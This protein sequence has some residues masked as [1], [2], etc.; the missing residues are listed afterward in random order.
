M[1]GHSASTE[2]KEVDKVRKEEEVKNKLLAQGRAVLANEKPPYQW[3][4]EEWTCSRRKV[5]CMFYKNKDDKAVPS[6]KND[7]F[8]KYKQTCHRRSLDA[9][10]TGTASSN[11]TC[12]IDSE[13]EGEGDDSD[14]DNEPLPFVATRKTNKARRTTTVTHQDSA[15]DTIDNESAAENDESSNEGFVMCDSESSNDDSLDLFPRLSG[16]DNEYCNQK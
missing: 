9:V 2:Q 1:Y 15:I 8:E 10:T 13:G 11:N 7:M 6:R 14:D 5:M 4:L 12:N 3:S 16:A